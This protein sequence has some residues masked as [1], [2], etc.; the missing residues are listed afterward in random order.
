VALISQCRIFMAKEPLEE[1]VSIIET[2]LA[3]KTI[4]EHFREQAELIDRR[5]DDSFRAQAELI[6]RLFAH[7]FDEFD[8]KWDTKFEAKLGTTLEAK[9]API[10]SDLAAVR[11]AVKTILARLK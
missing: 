8:R 11:D 6:D 4:E 1:R 5:F 3:G 7:R 10:R 9:L 2:Q